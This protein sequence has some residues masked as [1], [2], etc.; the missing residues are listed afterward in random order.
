MKKYSMETVVG[1]EFL[2]RLDEAQVAFLDEIEEFLRPDPIE[3]D[4]DFDHESQIGF[5]NPM[6][7]L[8]VILFLVASRQLI[9][10]LSA[11]E[12]K[13]AYLVQVPLEGVIGDDGFL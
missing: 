6:T 13:L 10:F 12:L 1:I 5:D 11:Q 3:S 7:R 4:G 9:L 2:E 8:L